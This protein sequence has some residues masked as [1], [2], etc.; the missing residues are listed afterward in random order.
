ML[1]Y[2]ANNSIPWLRDQFEMMWET[3]FSPTDSNFPCTP[4]RPPNRPWTDRQKRLFMANHNLNVGVIVRDI[5][6]LVPDIQR[7]DQTNNRTGPGSVGVA[8]EDCIMAWGRPPNVV[9]VDFAEE[10]DVEY[11]IM[12]VVAQ[13]NGVAWHGQQLNFATGSPQGWSA[14]ESLLGA[15]LVLLMV[16]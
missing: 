15:T 13:A 4:Y 3:P 16:W 10:G 14:I 7:I 9:L 12:Q 11:S 8:V 6:L 5:N 1:D 2:G